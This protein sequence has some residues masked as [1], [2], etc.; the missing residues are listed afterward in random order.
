MATTL[1]HTDTRCTIHTSQLHHARTRLDSLDALPRLRVGKVAHFWT[2]KSPVR[3]RSVWR[4]RRDMWMLTNWQDQI[5]QCMPAKFSWTPTT[6]PYYLTVVDSNQ[7]ASPKFAYPETLV[8]VPRKRASATWLVDATKGQNVTVV[9]RDA[10]GETAVSPPLV[11]G[12][13]SDYCL[14]YYA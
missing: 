5:F 1:T 12:Q 8:V 7:H 2:C 4:L 13:G 9:V 14:D 6:G 3:L 11:V 10:T